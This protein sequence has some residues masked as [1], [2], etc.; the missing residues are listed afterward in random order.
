MTN[1]NTVTAKKRGQTLKNQF[2]AVFNNPSADTVIISSWNEWGSIRLQ[3]VFDRSKAAYTDT[4]DVEHN[5]D[6][7]PEDGG[8]GTLYYD[9]M[10]NCISSFR[11]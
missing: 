4:F 1:P 5:R 10:K 3:N 7:E 6:I 8:A 11:S 9:L 2:Q